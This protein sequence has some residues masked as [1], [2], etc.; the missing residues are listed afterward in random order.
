MQALPRMKARNSGPS[1]L[2]TLSPPHHFR[3][4]RKE[5]GFRNRSREC[6]CRIASENGEKTG[7]FLAILVNQE[8]LDNFLP[9]DTD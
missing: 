8:N 2:F 6:F 3:A 7:Y 4:E 9:F 1:G 5:F